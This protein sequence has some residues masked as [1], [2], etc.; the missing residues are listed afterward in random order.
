MSANQKL[1]SKYEN[2]IR[3]TYSIATYSKNGIHASVFYDLAIISGIN[4]NQLAEEIFHTS[5]KTINRHKVDKKKL[6]A[7]ISERTLKLLALYK[8]GI[9]VFGSTD[10]FNNWLVKPAFGLGNKIPYELMDTFSG[11]DLIYDEVVRIEYGDLA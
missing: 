5:L 3:D 11:I 8:K 6:N 9:E 7:Q 10:S 4:K 2:T 1:F